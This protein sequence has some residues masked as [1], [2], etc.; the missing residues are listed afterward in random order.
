[1]YRATVELSRQG[2]V[3]SYVQFPNADEPDLDEWQETLAAE[4]RLLEAVGPQAGEL[5]FIG[6]SLG[7]LNFLYA[8]QVGALQ[9]H[10]DR[11]LLVA[12]ADPEFFLDSPI[13]QLT[14]EF[15]AVKAGLAAKTGSLSLVASDNDKWLPR[16][17]HASFADPLGVTPVVI[18]GALHL[19]ASDGWGPWA[20]VINWVN[21]PAADLTQR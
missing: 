21:D 2:H 4:T 11:V 6:H 19:A 12:P 16:G 5:I 15:E 14:H 18:E 1:M 7:A 20:G 10:F 9:A 13:G 17:I 3:V 8:A